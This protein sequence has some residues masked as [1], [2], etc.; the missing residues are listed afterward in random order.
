[1]PRGRRVETQPFAGQVH[2]K[3]RQETLFLS[4]KCQ[5]IDER[6]DSINDGWFSLD[7]TGYDPRETARLRIVDFPASYHNRAGVLS[8]ADGHSELRRWEDGRTTPILRKRVPLALGRDSPDNK[9]VE[10]LQVRSSAR[11]YNP[12]PF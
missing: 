11:A 12:T 9:D 5:F 1:M 4:P 6:E 7:M 3:C 8:F 2:E 10:W